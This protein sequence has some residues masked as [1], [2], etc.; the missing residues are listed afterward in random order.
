MLCDRFRFMCVLFLRLRIKNH[1]NSQ[2]DFESNRIKKKKKMQSQKPNRNRFK[3]IYGYLKPSTHLW[4]LYNF[5]ID[6]L[7]SNL[8]C[9]S[10]S[11]RAGCVSVWSCVWYLGELWE[12]EIKNR[13]NINKYMKMTLKEEHRHHK[14]KEVSQKFSCVRYIMFL[15]ATKYT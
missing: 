7:N 14:I 5:L 13:N 2:A 9:E 12:E 8:V 1:T 4:L 10:S 3:L 15:M 6:Y 11:I